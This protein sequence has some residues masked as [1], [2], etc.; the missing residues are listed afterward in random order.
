MKILG[1]LLNADVENDTEVRDYCHITQ[2]I[3]WYRLLYQ[4]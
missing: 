2:Q 3:Y 1:T 4:S